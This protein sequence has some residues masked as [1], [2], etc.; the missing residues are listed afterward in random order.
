MV[1]SLVSTPGSVGGEIRVDDLAADSAGWRVAGG[2]SH[3]KDS[4]S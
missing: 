1:N 4:K 3:G 2:F